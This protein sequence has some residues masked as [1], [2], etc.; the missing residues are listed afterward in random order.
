MDVVAAVVEVVEALRAAPLA[1]AAA[2]L[3]NASHGFP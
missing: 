2:V 3:L 1:V